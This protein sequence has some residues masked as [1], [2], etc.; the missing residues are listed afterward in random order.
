MPAA[1]ANTSDAG[2]ILVNGEGMP[3]EKKNVPVPL[4]GVSMEA[5]VLEAGIRTTIRQRYRN[6]ENMAIETVYKFPLPT[7][8]AV[9]GFDV[10]LGGKV[11]RGEVEEREKAFE[12]YDDAM[13]AGDFAALMDQERPNVFTASIGNLLPGEEAV[14]V[15]R[16]ITPIRWEDD[17][18]RVQIPTC[19]A[20]RYAPKDEDREGFEAQRVAPEYEDVVPYG[21]NLKVTAA[22]AS[23]IM[24]AESPS[25]EFDVEMRDNSMTAILRRDKNGGAASLD[26]DVVLLIA[27]D[28]PHEPAAFVGAPARQDTV[29]T[30]R[31]LPEFDPKEYEGS[32]II[33]VLDRSGSME[34]DSIREAR[35]ALEICLRTLHEKD[36][37]NVLRFDDNFN[38]GA[39]VLFPK[40]LRAYDQTSLD[41]GVRWVRAT[42]TSGG[43][44]IMPPVRY[45]VNQARTSS[46]GGCKTQIV[47]LTDAE[48]SNDREV[49]KFLEENADV[50]RVFSFGIG[51]AANSFLIEAAAK[52]TDGM[53]EYIYPGEKIEPK[54]L[55]QFSRIGTPCMQDVR[56][57]W[58]TRGAE[59]APAGVP[60]VFDG[61]PLVV[62]ARV[63]SGRRL[64]RH[65]TLSARIGHK[66]ISWK[67]ALS[68]PQDAGD[69]PGLLWACERLRELEGHSTLGSAQTGRGAKARKSRLVE[70]SKEYGVLCSA[71]SMVAVEV[72]P[73]GEKATGRAE[74]R[75]VP[76]AIAA[77]WHGR[78]SV[79]P[80][81][82]IAAAC[83]PSA[84]RSM[85]VSKAG[86]PPSV[87]AR[88]AKSKL[89]DAGFD[90][91]CFM[92]GSAEYVEA[93]ETDADFSI[94]APSRA[95]DVLLA[96]AMTQRADGS[97][98]L[99]PALAEALGGADV[100]VLAA[101]TKTLKFVSGLKP[102]RAALDALLSTA[103]AVHLLREDSSGTW[104]RNIEKAE[105]WL[106]KFA[107]ES[108][109]LLDG[110]PLREA[111][112]GFLRTLR[113]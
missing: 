69:L 73:E 34:G 57:E 60:P 33:F 112:S 50:V 95:S 98:P 78:G 66:T 4:L 59:P 25:H 3:A 89:S 75:K 61:D 6:A 17:R 53:S 88:L 52:A 49:V 86:S 30:V 111:V 96:L 79:T 80:R 65:V 104:R 11:V 36:R 35:N 110:A 76:V 23:R 39:D 107:W 46:T 84:A 31:F 54:V 106:R 16:Y 67:V 62:S 40:A 77:G 43:T 105:R 90:D 5:E 71:T 81:A 44:E 113:S 28:Q 103:I 14:V 22:L 45:A 24:N 8:A 9:C 101:R 51:A 48:V 87:R 20:P 94:P 109:I 27:V 83:M 13:S 68:Q 92:V 47:L 1:T 100:R 102:E 12:R 58:G 64:P 72:R 37:F 108:D 70:L 42:R 74:L 21:L 99:G 38:E 93:V 56:I 63:P 10:L 41:E 7:Q 32:D 26:R 91:T 29:V 15:L 18:I 97:F 85:S 19:V 55:R 82:G 2:L